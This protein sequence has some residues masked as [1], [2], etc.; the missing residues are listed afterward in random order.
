MRFFR[1]NNNG[2]TAGGLDVVTSINLFFK[3][4][5]L[6]PIFLLALYITMTMMK[7]MIFHGIPSMNKPTEEQQQQL[8]EKDAAI[9]MPVPVSVPVPAP[10]TP[11][12]SQ[13]IIEELKPSFTEKPFVQTQPPV[14]YTSPNP[15]AMTDA[16]WA[17]FKLK[18][19]CTEVWL[20]EYRNNIN[21]RKSNDVCFQ[22]E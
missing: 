6:S 18:K 8:R 3:A 2:Y 19:H 16:E 5:L 1:N 21:A 20:P 11:V 15:S 7:H 14:T 9:G 10:V 13:P 17:Q 4:L 12:A 22:F